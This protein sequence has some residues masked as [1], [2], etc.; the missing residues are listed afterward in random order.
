MV[1]R[2]FENLRYAIDRNKEI[3]K[4]CIKNNKGKRWDILRCV[5]DKTHDKYA[6]Q[7]R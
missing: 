2:G 5:I 4:L 1:K 6:Q 3:G 7:Q